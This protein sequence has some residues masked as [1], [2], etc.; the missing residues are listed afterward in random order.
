MY[1]TVHSI[2]SVE[3]VVETVTQ[4]AL[5]AWPPRVAQFSLEL[6]SQGVHLALCDT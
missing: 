4:G 5:P 2:K 3:C 6:N 1:F